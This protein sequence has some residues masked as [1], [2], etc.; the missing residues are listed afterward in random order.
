MAE[1]DNAMS[2][3]KDGCGVTMIKAGCGLLFL[4]LLIPLGLALLALL[5]SL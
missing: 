5:A 1:E 3:K 2:E 4:G